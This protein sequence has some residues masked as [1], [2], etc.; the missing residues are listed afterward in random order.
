[1]TAGTAT[2]VAVRTE[3]SSGLWRGVGMHVAAEQMPLPDLTWTQ[4]VENKRALLAGYWRG[5]GSSRYI[6]GGP[7]VVVECGTTRRA[8]P[9]GLLPLCPDPG[10]AARIG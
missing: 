8:L 10:A 9:G 3:M 1:M 2:A 4:S 5:D 6:R 7:S